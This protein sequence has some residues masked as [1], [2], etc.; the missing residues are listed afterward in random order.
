[1][2]SK[3]A[4]GPWMRW[5]SSWAQ[6]R[7]PATEGMFLCTGEKPG[8]THSTARLSEARL[9]APPPPRNTLPA[10]LH[11]EVSLCSWEMGA[12]GDHLD[13]GESMEQG[14]K[15]GVMPSSATHWPS[16]FTSV[17]FNLATRLH[18]VGGW[19]GSI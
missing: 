14:P 13:V 1:M 3:L 12:P 8:D 7:P 15:T 2:R 5:R 4:K 18:H 11:A 10:G 19:E 9:P 17:T 16:K 6:Q